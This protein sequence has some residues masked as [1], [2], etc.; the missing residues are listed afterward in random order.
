MFGSNF[1]FLIIHDFGIPRKNRRSKKLH[2]LS[3]IAKCM[4]KYLEVSSITSKEVDVKNCRIDFLARFATIYLSQFFSVD[5][6]GE[7]KSCFLSYVNLVKIER[8][9]FAPPSSRSD[10]SSLGGS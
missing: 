9:K 2:L 8:G 7:F 4:L 6:S 1:H 10:I 3:V 5:V